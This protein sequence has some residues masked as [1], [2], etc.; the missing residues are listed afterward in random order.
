VG[1]GC[2]CLAESE[3]WDVLHIS[4]QRWGKVV[5]VLCAHHG[6]SRVVVTCR[7]VPASGTDGLRVLTV[8]APSLDEALLLAREL[9]HLNSLVRGELL[10]VDQD[11]SRRLTLGVLTIAQGHP[12]LFE[13]ADGQAVA[14]LLTALPPDPATVDQT[15]RDLTAQ[16]QAL[17]ADQSALAPPA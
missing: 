3:G 16:T 10:G 5:G 2:G 8:D 14:G 11:M 13:L 17:A 15:L 9:P 4:G 7:R 12:K 1:S 6:L